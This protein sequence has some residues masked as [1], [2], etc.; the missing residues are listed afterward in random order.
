MTAALAPI[1]A[2][3]VRAQAALYGTAAMFE[4]PEA[5]LEAT[6]KAYLAG[7]RQMDAYSPIPVEGVAEALG[8]KGTSMPL[9]VLLG[10]IVGGV[11]GWAVQ[12]YSMAVDYPFNIGGRPFNSWPMFIPIIFELTVLFAALSGVFGMLL[13]NGL[14]R[15]HHPIF[16][17]ADIERATRDRCFLCIETADPRWDRKRTRRFLENLRPLKLIEV[18]A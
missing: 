9:I 15:P 11:T 8:R 7:Y 5:L 14:P 2:E 12:W 1:P 16:K 13:L 3:A 6:R 18:E 17:A 4:T 10:G